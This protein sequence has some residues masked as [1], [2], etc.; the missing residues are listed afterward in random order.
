VIREMLDGAGLSEA[1]RPDGADLIVLNTCAV[2]LRS[3]AEGRKWISRI[4]RRSPATR[5]VATGCASEIDPETLSGA[6]LVVRQP[7]KHSI[8]TALG[9]PPASHDLKANID[10]QIRL[11]SPRTRAYLRIQDGC[12]RR[13]S[14]CAVPFARGRSRSKSADVAVQEARRLI[15]AGYP[16]IV[17]CGT[18]LGSYR[19]APSVAFAA[20]LERLVDLPGTARF[21]I[22]SIDVTDVTDE[23]LSLMSSSDRI[24]PHLH[25]PLQSGDPDILRAMR[26]GYTPDR[27][28]A[29]VEA[30][31]NSLDRPALTTDCMVG[32]PGETDTCFE[33]T[34]SVVRV[35]AFSRI[36]AFRFS[37]RP[38]TEASRLPQ[39]LP[40][41]TLSERVRVLIDEGR[42]LARD[43]RLSLLPDPR[44]GRAPCE[45][46]VVVERPEASAS[47][48]LAG[49][50]VRVRIDS[51]LRRGTLLRTVARGT[52][53]TSLLA[54]KNLS[55]L[56]REG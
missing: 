24:C 32:F 3:S 11:F 18:D 44:S 19:P 47:I 35:A 20:L 27:F 49:R 38:R 25:I 5:I 17:L 7:E 48:G 29:T 56:S 41:R 9:L 30:A 28:L 40:E 50:Y 43:Y 31:R 36:H 12:S 51:R 34:L 39:T 23:L 42:R 46:A 37:S 21:R 52:D 13:C 1:E 54:D 2:T 33:N 45:L 15:E 16:E 8:L 6:D 55:I 22:S 26:R 14:F 4:R 10:M 53:G